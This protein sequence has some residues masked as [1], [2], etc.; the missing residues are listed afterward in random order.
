MRFMKRDIHLK[1]L[2]FLK[3]TILKCFNNQRIF[4]HKIGQITLFS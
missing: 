4:N 3:L 2:K 1:V